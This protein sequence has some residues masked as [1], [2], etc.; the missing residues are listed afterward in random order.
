MRDRAR[1]KLVMVPYL[2]FSTLVAYQAD[3]AYGTKLERVQGIMHDIETN[4]ASQHWYLPMISRP[5]DYKPPSK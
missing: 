3:F 2:A 1:L 4:E 5:T